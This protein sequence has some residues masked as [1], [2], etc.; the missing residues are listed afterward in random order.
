[1]L[2]FVITG[3]S[4]RA[5]IAGNGGNPGN[6]GNADNGGNPGNAGNGGIAGNPDNGGNAD[7]QCT[8][9]KH[10]S[11]RHRNS[12]VA[13]SILRSLILEKGTSPGLQNPF[14]GIAYLY[15]FI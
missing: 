10:L 1:M 12:L 2:R 11:M 15:S 5:D 4:Q 6:A 8:F 7:S 14:P 13:N 9:P 3:S